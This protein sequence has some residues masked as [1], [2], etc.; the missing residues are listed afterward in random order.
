[1]KTSFYNICRLIILVIYMALCLLPSLSRNVGNNLML[2]V[3][4][5]LI[6]STLK[7]KMLIDKEVIISF[8]IFI[9]Y[10]LVQY[11]RVSSITSI[12]NLLENILFL[13]PILYYSL[14]Q[15]KDLIKTPALVSFV[16]IQ[17]YV[18]IENIVLLINKPFLSKYLTG[19]VAYVVSGYR[20]SNLGSVSSVFVSVCICIY[21]LTVYKSTDNK[22]LRLVYILTIIVN[23]TY[24]LAAKST[25]CVIILIIGI[26]ILLG[27][28]IKQNKAI[29]IIAILFLLVLLFAF[30]GGIRE[31]IIKSDMANDYKN[32]L[33]NIFDWV[34]GTSEIGALGFI[35]GR[36]SDYVVSLKSFVFNPIFGVGMYYTQDIT[37]V[38]MH[39]EALDFLARYGF[40]GLILFLLLMFKYVKSLNIKNLVMFKTVLGV[41]SLYVL[42]NPMIN[43]SSGIALFLIF[44]IILEKTIKS[45]VK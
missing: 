31:L 15:D 13:I 38:G 44:P 17:T 41:L 5:L 39:S 40:I 8:C 4:A 16:I 28:N 32:R 1:M 24:V 45:E 19:G 43:R 9:I 26:V 34:T 37:V 25:L 18:G 23:T 11:F 20:K 14:F 33:T 27:K 22:K 35:N 7:L 42:L 6:F 3:V 29:S 10:L 30:S 21:L 36:F 2:V 12:G